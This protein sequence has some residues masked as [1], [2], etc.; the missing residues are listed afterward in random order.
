MGSGTEVAVAK[1]PEK[2]GPITLAKMIA[3]VRE[4][5]KQAEIDGR[6]QDLRFEV[7]EVELELVVTAEHET[8]AGG[9][10]K[11][12]VIEAGADATVK[13]GQSHTVKVRLKPASGVP[14]S[15]GS[16]DRLLVTSDGV[17]PVIE[18]DAMPLG[19]D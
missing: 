8:T 14:R 17:E 12:W 10:V 16:T 2:S 7:Q 4:E 15:D 5:L 3:A 1:K 9:G 11:V 6:G 19:N 13:K 18:D